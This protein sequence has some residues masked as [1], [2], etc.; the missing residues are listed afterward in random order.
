MN[1]RETRRG[2]EL[3]E[4]CSKNKRPAARYFVSNSFR[5][6]PRPSVIRTFFKE[7]G[8]ILSEA[9]RQLPWIK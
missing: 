3:E 2:R 9:I 6:A 1:W 8:L 5:S 7:L 4:I